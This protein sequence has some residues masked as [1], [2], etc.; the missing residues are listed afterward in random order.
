MTNVRPNST[1]PLDGRIAAFNASGI[2]ALPEE[3]VSM[4]V[5]AILEWWRSSTPVP[6]SLPRAACPFADFY[7]G[8]FADVEELSHGFGGEGFLDPADF[9]DEP[10]P[11][12]ATMTIVGIFLT[13][14]TTS[15][16]AL[17]REWLGRLPSPARRRRRLARLLSR[18]CVRGPASSAGPALN[19]LKRLNT[20]KMWP[21]CIPMRRGSTSPDRPAAPYR[22]N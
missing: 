3:S 4:G 10:D 2:S 7:A 19:T 14:R 9:P 17:S 16:P 8:D 5:S 13:I 15:M 18:G 22:G 6:S 11:T 1:A 21:A 20:P 12:Q